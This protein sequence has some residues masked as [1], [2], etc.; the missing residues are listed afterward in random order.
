MILVIENK[1]EKYIKLEQEGEGVLFEGL[2]ML[3]S[4]GGENFID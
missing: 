3:R 2:C 1:Q 4:L